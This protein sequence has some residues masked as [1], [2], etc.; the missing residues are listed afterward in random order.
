M[1]GVQPKANVM[2]ITG[3]TQGPSRGGPDGHAV[4]TLQP[5][6]LESDDHAHSY[7]QAAG[8]VAQDRFVALQ[9]MEQGAGSSLQQG[10]H[11]TETGHEQQRGP[12][13]ASPVGRHCCGADLAGP[14]PA[15]PNPA[16][17]WYSAHAHAGHHRQ[18]RGHQR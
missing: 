3:A 5:G 4:L 2:P 1:H 17:D 12:E 16:R 14:N 8:D 13:Q 10:E 18:V 6:K 7:D 9:R 15:G 11:Q